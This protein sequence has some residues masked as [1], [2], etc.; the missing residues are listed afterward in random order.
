MS[1][2][3][4]FLQRLTALIL[5]PL[6]LVHLGIIAY[7]VRGGLSAGEILERTHGS[8]GWALFYCGF[9]AAAAIHGAIG[10][11]TILVEWA[12]LG[13]RAAGGIAWAVALA[14]VLLGV[15]A[16]WAMVGGGAP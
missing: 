10:L 11:R 5:V 7:A 13:P 12:G 9:V 2:R 14:L 8:F 15:R 1:A 16:I 4:F 6:V 3:L